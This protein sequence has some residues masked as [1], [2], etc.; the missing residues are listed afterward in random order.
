[1]EIIN[2]IKEKTATKIYQII[3]A[4]PHSVIMTELELEPRFP[5]FQAIISFRIIKL[6][7][8][9]FFKSNSLYFHTF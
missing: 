1:M 8:L 9:Q 7:P 5:D 2:F 6:S 3:S 4:C